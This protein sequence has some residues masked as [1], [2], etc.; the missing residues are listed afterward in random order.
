[1]EE[2]I[3]ELKK[4]GMSKTEAE[5]YIRNAM[6]KKIKTGMEPAYK[7][8]QKFKKDTPEYKKGVDYL[9]SILR[10]KDISITSDEELEMYK[11]ILCEKE[12]YKCGENATRLLKYIQQNLK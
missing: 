4:A 11:N 2:A 6:Y 3:Q 10:K 9:E 12:A 7:D 1:M 8:L 5:K